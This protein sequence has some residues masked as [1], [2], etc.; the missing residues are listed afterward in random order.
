[1]ML[2]PDSLY[3]VN[4]TATHKAGTLAWRITQNMKGCPPSRIDSVIQRHI[5]HRE[6]HRST[7]PDTLEIPGLKGRKPYSMSPDDLEQVY[8][9]G[10]FKDNPLLHPELQ[11]THHGHS[12]VPVP[13]MLWRDDWVA[14]SLLFS[15][16]LLIYVINHLRRKFVQQAKDFFFPIQNKPTLFAEETA[17]EAHAVFFMIFL[18]SLLGGILSF[19]FAQYTLDLFLSQV[20]PYLLLFIYT[21]CFLAYFLLKRMASRFVNWIFFEKHQ[22]EA[23][24]EATSFL[25]SIE[26]VL[27][28]PLA[29]VFVYFNIPIIH[30]V[31]VL[32]FIVLLVKIL[33]VYKCYSLFFPK[34]VCLFHLFA[35]LCALEL[36]PMLALWKSLTFITDNLII[37]Y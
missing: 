6:Q 36:V 34:L 37:K 12:A 27:I 28:F 13:Y 8:T 3:T 19:I 20:S 4:D 16:V 31:V 14:G 22:Q 15:F 33:L 10:F 17:F 26:C 25:I 23:W 32:G 5:P 7:R 11:V 21:G 1:M 9:L 35:Y 29:L 24:N 30:T 2:S 18:L